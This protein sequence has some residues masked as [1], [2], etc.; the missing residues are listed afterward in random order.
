MRSGPQQSHHRLAVHGVQGAGRLV[1][2]QQPALADDPAG[3]CNPLPLAARELVG[4]AIGALRDI[5]LFEGLHARRTCRFRS[6]AVQLEREGDVL[7]RRQPREQVEVLEDVADR[8]A[9]HLRSIGTRDGGEVDPVHEHLA[10]GRLLEASGDRQERALAG[11][12]RAHD[13]HQL[14][15]LDGE[16]DL[17]ERAHLGR[18]G[19]IDLRYL[20]Q[21]ECACHRETSIG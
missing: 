21:F 1:R 13:R 18:P 8:P 7:D 17:M 6:H 12:A 16:V 5:E 10:A 14:A 11:A 19:A 9:A 3:D 4:V 20:A 15:A 2:E